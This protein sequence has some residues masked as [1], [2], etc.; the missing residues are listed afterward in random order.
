MPYNI[1][2]I[3]SR[4]SPQWWTRNLV[5]T[6]VLR[7]CQTLTIIYVSD[8]WRRNRIYAREK[9]QTYTKHGPGPWTTPNFFPWTTPN[10]FP[11]TT[12]NFR[13]EIAS[14]NMK[15][16]FTGG[17]GMKNTDLYLLLTLASYVMRQPTPSKATLRWIRKLI[18][19]CALKLK[20]QAI[21]YPWH[22]FINKPSGADLG[23][24]CTGCAPPS[25][26]V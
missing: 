22:F 14:V 19:F 3:Y 25:L 21:L 8:R 13:K 16:N 10:F 4:T 1:R 5:L 17:Q 9:G 24:G 12:P 18:T 7:K 2:N 6:F 23:G 26:R 15:I 11:W 20:F